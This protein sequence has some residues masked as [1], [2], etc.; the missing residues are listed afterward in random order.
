MGADGTV[1]IK[2]LNDKKKLFVVAQDEETSTVYGMPRAIA[3]T[4]L[5]NSVVPL[6]NVADEIIKNVGVR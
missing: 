1:G 2:A 4:G 3:N 6:I 5:C